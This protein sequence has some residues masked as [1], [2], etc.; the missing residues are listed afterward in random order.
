MLEI[1]KTKKLKAKNCSK[2]ACTMP[3]LRH[4]P[5]THTPVESFFDSTAGGVFN[6]AVAPY[7][8]ESMCAQTSQPDMVS[9]FEVDGTIINCAHEKYCVELQERTVKSYKNSAL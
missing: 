4:M 9:T 2:S 8:N 7:S 6:Y 1:V 5:V 3:E